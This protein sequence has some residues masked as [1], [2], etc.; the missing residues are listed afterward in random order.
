MVP[1]K[2]I[3]ATGA[4]N[5]K[6]SMLGYI[7]FISDVA[8]IKNTRLKTSPAA[9]PK[10]TLPKIFAIFIFLNQTL[11]IHLLRNAKRT[12]WVAGCEGRK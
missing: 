1:K 8:N 4:M 5:V 9:A 6:P 3:I 12:S 10:I 2:T 7:I 11:L